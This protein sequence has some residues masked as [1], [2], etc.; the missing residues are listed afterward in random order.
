[1]M[2]AH[3]DATPSLLALDTVLRLPQAEVRAA[4]DLVKDPW[5]PLIELLAK[6]R[7]QDRAQKGKPATAANTKLI[8]EV[9]PFAEIPLSGMNPWLVDTIEIIDAH[10]QA[11]AGTAQEGGIRPLLDTAELLAPF[12]TDLPRRRRPQLNIE[13]DGRPTFATATDEFYIHLTVDE[14]NRLTWYAVVGGAEH[15]NEAVA[16]D[17]RKFPPELTQL[18]AL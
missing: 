15:F 17:G 11:V 3:T 14:P 16:F 7:V 4:T 9:V 5:G 18:F 1:M 13:S 10:R 8:D 2:F 6:G 12:I